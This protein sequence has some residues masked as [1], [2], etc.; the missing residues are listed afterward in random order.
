[1]ETNEWREYWKAN[2]NTN[3]VLCSALQLRSAGEATLVRLSGS[4]EAILTV[5]NWRGAAW[6]VR[7]ND[8]EHWCHCDVTQWWIEIMIQRNCDVGCNELLNADDVGRPHSLRPTIRKSQD[9]DAG[10]VAPTWAAR[11]GDKRFN[12]LEALLPKKTLSNSQ[13]NGYYP[14]RPIIIIFCISKPGR[15]SKKHFR[16]RKQQQEVVVNPWKSFTQWKQETRRRKN[17]MLQVSPSF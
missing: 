10:D 5:M 17:R 9:Q 12:N 6:K 11:H 2:S 16:F 4:S 15:G 7:F 8:Q 3:A 13:H 14:A 1:M